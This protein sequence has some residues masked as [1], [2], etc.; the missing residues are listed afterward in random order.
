MRQR[1]REHVAMPTSPSRR[2][3]G[4]KPNRRRALE[5]LASCPDGCTETLMV[6]H[7]FTPELMIELLRAGFATAQPER[8]VA[9][10][11]TVEVCRVKITDGGRSVLAP[12]HR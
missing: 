9:A 6:A 10:G 12:M 2:R 4:P 11:R 1:S 8:Y 7:G 3:R 5:L